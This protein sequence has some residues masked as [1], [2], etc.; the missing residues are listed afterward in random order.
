MKILYVQP[1]PGI[2]GSKISLASILYCAPKE[3][4][5][6]VVLSMP[7]NN[8]Y[9]ETIQEYVKKIYYVDLPTWQKYRRNSFLQKMRA[10]FS[11]IK[12]ILGFIPPII[13]LFNIIRI[14]K[15]DL[16][17]T[18]N[19]MCPVGAIAA[20][21]INRPHVWHIR[22]AIGKTRQYPLI[23]GDVISFFLFKHLSNHIICNSKYTAEI[24]QKHNI[25]I[26]IILNGLRLV[27]FQSGINQNK[28]MKS[29]ITIGM[30]GNLT[31]LKNHALFLDVAAIIAEKFPECQFIIFG[32]NDDLGVNEYTRNLKQKTIELGLEER[33]R[34][35]SFI[36]D[37]V[38]IMN[39]IDILVHPAETEGSGR[40][41]MEA[42]AAGK[43]VIGVRSG[44]VQE[45][46]EDGINGFLVEPN[47]PYQLADRVQ[48]LISH[49]DVQITIG[50]RARDYAYSQFSNEKMIKQITEI[51]TE[52]IGL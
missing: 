9:E 4:E 29:P 23:L 16:V 25:P 20:K 11:T 6:F 5:S 22:E 2:G 52:I 37:P 14:E 48:Y 7:K 46:I 38:E 31:Q 21:I 24:F 47:N 8:E 34:W 43:P 35:S 15:I 39:S 26:T 41:I 40:V 3:Q 45:L 36:N 1:G 32:G 27:D 19:G 49:P 51:Y 42:M 44:G 30:I 12:R 13:R 28:T 17:H 33:L 18:N 10:P 50:D